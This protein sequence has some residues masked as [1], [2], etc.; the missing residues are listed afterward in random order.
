M[1]EAMKNHHRNWS[2]NGFCFCILSTIAGVAI[3]NKQVGYIF[4]YTYF[5][6]VCTPQRLLE[7]MHPGIH[8]AV[9]SSLREIID[10]SDVVV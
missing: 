9:P 8:V 2:L 10:K 4:K 6:H 1:D 7:Y 5:L 3:G